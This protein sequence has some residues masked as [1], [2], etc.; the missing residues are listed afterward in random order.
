MATVRFQTFS[1]LWRHAS[2]DFKAAKNELIYTT[3]FRVWAILVVLF[4]PSK[5]R[6]TKCFFFFY[7]STKYDPISLVH[8]VVRCNPTVFRVQNGTRERHVL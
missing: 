1:L 7:E 8:A 2:H 3:D 6:P 5:T 4:S